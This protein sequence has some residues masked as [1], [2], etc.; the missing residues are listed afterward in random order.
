MKYFKLVILISLSAVCANANIKFNDILNA[1]PIFIDKTKSFLWNIICENKA[2]NTNQIID[3]AV[4]GSFAQGCARLGGDD[5]SDIDI[6]IFVKD[7]KECRFFNP[8]INSIKLA[9]AIDCQ[10]DIDI[11]VQTTNMM[12]K[13][14]PDWIAYS[15]IDRKCYGRPENKPRNVKLIRENGKWK[16][17]NRNKYKNIANNSN[18]EADVENDIILTGP[19]IYNYYEYKYIKTFPNTTYTNTNFNQPE[20][21]TYETTVREETDIDTKTYDTDG[22]LPDNLIL[23]LIDSDSDSSGPDSEGRT[24]Q[25]FYEK[26]GIDGTITKSAAKQGHN[27]VYHIQETWGSSNNDDIDWDYY[28]YFRVDDWADNSAN[29]SHVC[30]LNL[31]E[32][33]TDGW[34]QSQDTWYPNG[35]FEET[36]PVKNRIIPA[37][38]DVFKIDLDPGVYCVETEVADLSFALEISIYNNNIFSDVSKI[39]FTNDFCRY[40]DDGQLDSGQRL[41]FINEKKGT[42]YIEL[43]QRFGM[44]SFPDTKYKVR[45]LKARPVILVH[46]INSSPKSSSDPDT[47]FEHMRDCLGYFKEVAPC[48]CYDFPWDSSQPH[49][50]KGFEHYVGINS[51]ISDSLYE[52]VDERYDLH[53]DYKVNILLHSMGGFIVRYQ[54]DYSEFANM[55]NQVL[56]INSPQYGSDLA[57]FIATRPKAAEKFNKF[58]MFFTCQ[59][60]YIHMCRGG[61]TV[62][63][64]HHEK[65]INIPVSKIAFTVGTKRGLIYLSLPGIMFAY[66]YKEGILN[67]LLEEKKSDLNVNGIKALFI[68]RYTIGLKRS[69]GIVPVTSQ[70]LLNLVP[71]IPKANYYFI[72]KHHTEAQKLSLGNM[73]SCRELYNLIKTRM[74]AQ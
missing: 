35:L 23:H 64:M 15:I 41:Y 50:G 49:N 54:L 46:G 9:K 43:K 40:D 21:S 48:I 14:N 68:E 34:L 17:I 65:D 69:D 73:N 58:P 55:V 27:K 4:V 13:N 67:D 2:I 39:G 20:N 22:D 52:F 1:P 19:Y 38:I 26:Y 3:I 5:P 31:T 25:W 59:E 72:K 8:K 63:K 62:W 71:N 74:N 51:S 28:Y 61:E 30:Q 57:N 66:D 12:E 29:T 70:N 6:I 60:N 11:S 16:A 44:E 45:V 56:F 36:S 47:T 37:D 10:L 18:F 32:I 24:T 7:K 33:Y 42:C 53:G